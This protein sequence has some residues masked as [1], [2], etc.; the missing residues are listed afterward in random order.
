MKSHFASF[1]EAK[2][3]IILRPKNEMKRYLSVE[4]KIG[5]CF[6]PKMDGENNG[7]PYFLMDDLG[8]FPTPIFGSTPIYNNTNPPFGRVFG[9]HNCKKPKLWNSHLPAQDVVTPG[10]MVVTLPGNDGG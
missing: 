5:G 8:G 2:R 6:T 7:K 1:M 3:S 10:M 9:F 4:P